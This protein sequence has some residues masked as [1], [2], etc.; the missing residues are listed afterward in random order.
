MLIFNGYVCPPYRLKPIRQKA[1]KVYS[2]LVKFLD[3]K[4]DDAN[5]E[6]VCH[7]IA[8]GLDCGKEVVLLSMQPFRGATMSKPFLESLAWKFAASQRSMQRGVPLI[9]TPVLIPGWS[10]CQIINGRSL[11]SGMIELVYYVLTGPAVGGHV[12]EKL[13]VPQFNAIRWKLTRRIGKSHQLRPVD[14]QGMLFAAFLLSDEGR[15][16]M[17]WK[18]ISTTPFMFKRNRKIMSCIFDARQSKSTI[19]LKNVFFLPVDM[20]GVATQDLILYPD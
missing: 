12:V 8:A 17:A 7:R 10:Y 15:T 3:S 18:S 14:M 11:V 9:P 16:R 4:L 2:L 20:D 13:T 19:R 1:N 5:Y 6:E